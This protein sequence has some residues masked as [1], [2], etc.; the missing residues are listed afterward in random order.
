MLSDVREDS[1]EFRPLLSSSSNSL[2]IVRRKSEI[3]RT[4]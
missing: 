2:A 3:E 4:G 1:E